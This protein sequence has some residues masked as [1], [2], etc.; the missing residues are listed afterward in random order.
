[1]AVGI[2]QRMQAKRL[3]QRALR[4]EPVDA[5]LEM[6]KQALRLDPDNRDAHRSAIA[7][8]Q[9]NSLWTD[10]QE[11][12]QDLAQQHPTAAIVRNYWGVLLYLSGQPEEA[13]AKMQEAKQIDP[14]YVTAR[15]NLA[16]INA[17]YYGRYDD[18]ITEYEETLQIAPSDVAHGNLGLY[19]QR[20]GRSDEALVHLKRAA[21]IKPSGYHLSALG[22]FFFYKGDPET[23]C[24]WYEKAF[25]RE[26]ASLGLDH[27]R[28]RGRLNLA[29]CYIDLQRYQDAIDTVEASFQLPKAKES[30]GLHRALGQAY[31][32]LGRLEQAVIHLEQALSLAADN[33]MAQGAIYRSL[34]QVYYKTGEYHKAGTAYQLSS[35]G[36][37]DMVDGQGRS[38][39]IVR[40]R[41]LARATAERPQDASVRLE[42]GK[43]LYAQGRW[44]DAER[45]LHGALSLRPGLAEAHFLIAWINILQDDPVEAQHH[46]CLTTYYQPQS[47]DS[48]VIAGLAA[49]YEGEYEQ[50]A[51]SFR[52]ALLL[53]PRSAQA[54]NYLGDVHQCEHRYEDAKSCFEQALAITPEIHPA[55]YNLANT[56]Y[57]LKEFAA[58]EDHVIRLL[59]AQP[60]HLMGWRL[61]GDIQIEMGRFEQAQATLQRAMAI[62]PYC[63]AV[64]EKLSQLQQRSP[65]A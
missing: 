51:M 6:L 48:Y 59:A 17:E 30:V 34:A 65:V 42:Y 20:V 26:H 58:A 1:M 23:A 57:Q 47:E 43:N 7:L 18:A 61:L 54:H 27:D 38:E 24:E 4:A 40:G 41:E 62:N 55:R 60:T 10:L 28:I 64:G 63:A 53:N 44:E 45:E 22:D 16:M 31:G 29:R 5:H 19:Y 33:E 11:F 3:Y 52:R 9:R 39:L 12:Y 35:T 15:N 25:S 14:T 56:L 36:R 13:Q 37:Y 2:W 49:L 32:A 50:A 21:E 8:G 46:I